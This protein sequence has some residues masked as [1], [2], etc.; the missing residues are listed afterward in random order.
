MSKEKPRWTVCYKIFTPGSPW[1]GSGWEFFEF[2]PPAKLRYD[3]L[4]MQGNYGIMMRPFHEK[5]DTPH[6]APSQR[7]RPLIEELPRHVKQ[8]Q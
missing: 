7:T 4:C 2:E 1:V 6:L 5:T 8:I 3:E